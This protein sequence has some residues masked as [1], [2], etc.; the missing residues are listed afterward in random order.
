MIGRV[1]AAVGFPLLQKGYFLGLRLSDALP[2]AVTLGSVQLDFD[3]ELFVAN[4]V[5]VC[6]RLVEVG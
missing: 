1:L 4:L 2:V 5:V 3:Q 6:E